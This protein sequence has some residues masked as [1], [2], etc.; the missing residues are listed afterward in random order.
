MLKKKKKE[1][2]AIE[3]K[4]W[5]PASPPKCW[6]EK[7]FGFVREMVWVEVSAQLII[8]SS[9]LILAHEACEPHTWCAPVSAGGKERA[10][11]GWFVR[12]GWLML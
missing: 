11:Q 7:L 6:A 1:I 2:E 9:G 5:L 12:V 4:T 3:N 10:Q 8:V